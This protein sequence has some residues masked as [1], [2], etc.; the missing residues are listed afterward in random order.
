MAIS[1]WVFPEAN[2]S[3]VSLEL[4]AAIRQGFLTVK[5]AG[6]W[7]GGIQTPA[8]ET[9]PVGKRFFSF[10]MDNEYIAGFDDGACEKTL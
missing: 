1:V 7:A 6:V 10:D 4:L 9:P 8:I 3:Q 2:I 5:A